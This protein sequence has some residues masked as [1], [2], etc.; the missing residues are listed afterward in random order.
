MAVEIYTKMTCGFCMRAKM[1]LDHKQVL[2]TE[3]KID[4]EPLLRKQMIKRS[5]GSF[6]VPQIF[7]HDQSIGG[8]D[9]LYSLHAKNRLDALLAGEY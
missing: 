2:Y 1:L 4:S 6:T 5:G 7:I 3:I 9:E 8:C